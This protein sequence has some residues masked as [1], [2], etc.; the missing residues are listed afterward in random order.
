MNRKAVAW[1]YPS[2]EHAAEFGKAEDGC[3]L[4]VLYEEIGAGNIMKAGP[5]DGIEEAEQWAEPIQATW[6]PHYQRHPL[7]GS[8]FGKAKKAE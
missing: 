1:A 4:V 5:F 2:S 8:K 7:P 3:H 6:C